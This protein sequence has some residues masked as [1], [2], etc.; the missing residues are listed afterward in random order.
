M[1][2]Y[3]TAT[4]AWTPLGHLG[5]NVDGCVSS[6]WAISG[7]GSTVVGNA[8]ADPA[9]GNGTTFYAHGVAWNSSEG[10]ID[11][12]SLYANDNRSS[13][14]EAVSHDGQV[15]AGYQ[16]SGAWKA[17]VWRKNPAGGYFPNT[18]L[19]I[20]PNGSATD[21]NNQLGMALAVSGD[22]NWIGGFGDWASGGEP[23]LW[24]E[25]TGYIGLGAM[26][27]AWS[28]SVTGLNHDGTIAV[29]FYD[30]GGWDPRIPFIRTPT[31]G[32]Q[33]LND[34]ISQTLGIDTGGVIVYTPMDISPNG[35]YITGIGFDPNSG[36]W[37]ATVAFRLELP[38]SATEEQVPPMVNSKL[39][40]IYPNPFRQAVSIG[41]ALEKME[42]VSLR[43]YNSRGQMVKEL[44]AADTFAGEHTLSWDGSDNSGNQVAAGIYYCRL[45]GIEWSAGRKILFLR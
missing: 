10:F 16:D 12:G 28:A 32:T 33:N 29:G 6:G 26:P 13:R 20:D 4:A 34:Y 14:A 9:N 38:G 1:A 21:E 8:W 44:L 5:F 18:F 7:D 11:L 45:Q 43:I 23:W 17:A 24:S 31:D 41:F 15:V 27:N 25:S 37:G 39:T 35:R 42:Q 2:V 36:P 30:F 3:N 19:L 40:E 22:G